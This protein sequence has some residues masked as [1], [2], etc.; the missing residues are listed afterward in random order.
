[1]SGYDYKVAGLQ[2]KCFTVITTLGLMDHFFGVVHTVFT[3]KVLS[4]WEGCELEIGK[5]NISQ[6]S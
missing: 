5:E 2:K 1:M 4:L 3:G 6:S